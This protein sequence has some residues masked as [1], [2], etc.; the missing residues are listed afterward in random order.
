[1]ETMANDW[2]PETGFQNEE[3]KLNK[4][5]YPKPA[6]GSGSRLGLS[7]VLNAAINEY[8]CSSTSGFGFKV[9]LHSP[10]E[11]PQIDEFGLGIANGYESRIIA[12]PAISSASNAVRKTP[13]RI[14]QCV[15]QNENFLDYYRVYSREVLI[16]SNFLKIHFY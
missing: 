4:E 8:Y 6:V 9:V 1:M 12:N 16:L 14:R 10:H 5:S 2:N 3:L 13:M 11:L 15:Y 7:L